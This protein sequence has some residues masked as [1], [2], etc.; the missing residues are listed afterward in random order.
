MEDDDDEDHYEYYDN[1]DD[2][3]YK[4]EDDEDSDS[5]DDIKY[6]KNDIADM[7]IESD[8]ETINNVED[9]FEDMQIE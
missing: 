6:C 5:E 2:E 8:K 1:E 7:Q 4:S 9:I 3:D